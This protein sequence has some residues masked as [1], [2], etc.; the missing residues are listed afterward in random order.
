MCMSGLLP[1]VCVP[2]ACLV[3]VSSE[4]GVGP[5]IGVTTHILVFSKMGSTVFRLLRLSDSC[6]P[7]SPGYNGCAT[8]PPLGFSDYFGVQFCFI[9]LL[10]RIK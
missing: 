4:E 3:P 2:G 8:P 1:Y 5:V 10:S 7:K 9:F 6:Y